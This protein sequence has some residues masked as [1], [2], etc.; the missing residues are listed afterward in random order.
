MQFCRPNIGSD[1]GDDSNCPGESKCCHA[2]VGRDRL[3]MTC[4]LP[5]E[6]YRP[7]YRPQGDPI[8]PSYYPIHEESYR[9]SYAPE[10]NHR[11]SY[12]P[13]IENNY[14]PSYRPPVEENYRPI[15]RPSE[16]DAY[17]PS[18]RP[19]RTADI[20][21]GENEKLQ[22]LDN[23]IPQVPI[24]LQEEE[25]EYIPVPE[26]LSDDMI[27]ADDSIKDPYLEG[28]KKGRNPESRMDNLIDLET[29]A[30]VENLIKNRKIRR[31][32]ESLQQVDVKDV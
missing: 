19:W 29:R 21:L 9:P 1:C 28:L 15:Y 8:R 12:R 11:P 27:F 16:E 17:R 5:E 18:Y 25:D 31:D 10:D 23:Q 13:P 30:Q 14:R 6:V 22:V 24:R 2:R 4:R 3:L 7:L 26:Q 20:S 32:E